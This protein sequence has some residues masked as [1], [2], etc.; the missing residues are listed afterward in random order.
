MRVKTVFL[1]F[2]CYD[3]RPNSILLE[4]HTLWITFKPPLFFSTP[5]YSLF[6]SKAS[7]V[8]AYSHFFDYFSTKDLSTKS[9]DNPVHSIENTI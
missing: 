8:K 1:F 6:H 4:N 3:N 7:F 5:K 9:V 2:F